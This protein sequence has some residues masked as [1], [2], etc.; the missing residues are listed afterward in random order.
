ME[1]PSSADIET[2][3][4]RIGSRLDCA[5]YDRSITS[6]QPSHSRLFTDVDSTVKIALVVA[7]NKVAAPPCT[8]GAQID[9]GKLSFD[10]SQELQIVSVSETGTHSIDEI[11]KVRSARAWPANH[12]PIL[13]KAT[14]GLGPDGIEDGNGQS[15]L[16]VMVQ[17]SDNGAPKDWVYRLGPDHTVVYKFALGNALPTFP[18]WYVLGEFDTVM[19]HYGK[20]L[21]VFRA[22]T[23]KPLWTWVPKKS[24]PF[25]I[26]MSLE[27][28]GIYVA[29]DENI[30]HLKD[31][32]MLTSQPAYEFF[33]SEPFTYSSHD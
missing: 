27:D 32:E 19:V 21:V 9:L 14:G 16:I 10:S 15:G 23:G 20:K 6:R 24:R 31:G 13:L 28:G 29:V 3:F 17:T 7:T 1:L 26:Q 22:S 30:L 12:P 18:G 33:L 11:E 5:P 25:V 4:T 8:A 2:G